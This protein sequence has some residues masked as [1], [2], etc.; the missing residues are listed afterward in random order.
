MNNTTISNIFSNGLS[1]IAYVNT[2]LYQF[3]GTVAYRLLKF[4]SIIKNPIMK[5]R[6]YFVVV[7]F[8]KISSLGFIISIAIQ[9][10]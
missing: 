10:L 9:H 2:I 3:M 7:T 1:N 5:N 4:K 6:T 8:S